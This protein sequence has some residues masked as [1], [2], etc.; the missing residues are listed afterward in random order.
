MS[1]NI[2]DL[3]QI[4]CSVYLYHITLH[5]RATSYR[6]RRHVAN[7]GFVYFLWR[8]CFACPVVLGNL[9]E[10][11]NHLG[12]N[13]GNI[14]IRVNKRYSATCPPPTLLKNMPALERKDISLWFTLTSR[15]FRGKEQAWRQ[16][17]HKHTHTKIPRWWKE[18]NGNLVK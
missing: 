7:L 17:T 9:A 3:S 6:A 13:A 8:Y 5:P 1:S 10:Q 14:L 18:A 16:N 4:V 15:I 12:S 11:A 2:S